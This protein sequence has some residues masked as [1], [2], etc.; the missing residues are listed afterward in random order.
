MKKY[1]FKT[2]TAFVTAMLL[3][4]LVGALILPS[5]IPD[6]ALVSPDETESSWLP[7]GCRWLCRVKEEPS[8]QVWQN[9]ADAIDKPKDESYSAT[10]YLCGV[11]PLKTVELA[12]TDT[13]CVVP[14]GQAIGISLRPDGILVAA[15]A[16]VDTPDG[17]KSPAKEAGLNAGDIIH[18]ING[19]KMGRVSDVTDFVQKSHETLTIQGKRNQK[20]MEWTVKPAYDK[21]GKAKIGLWIRDTVSGIGTLSFFTDSLFGALGHPISDI[22][23]GKVVDAA[24][25][26]I[27][28]A[29]IVNV[30]KGQ[31]GVPGSLCGIFTSQKIG[32][33]TQNTDCGVFGTSAGL[34]GKKV[35]IGRKEDIKCTKAELWCDIGNG[36]EHFDIEIVRVM[37]SADSSKGMVIHI[38]DDALI[39]RTGGIVQGMSGSPILQNGKLIGAVTHVFVNDPTRGYGIFIENMLAEAEKI[40]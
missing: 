30:D 24:G 19:T 21:N 18:T 35:P 12:R 29:S 27:Y 33:I 22:D 28:S 26:N 38:T 15:V 20:A 13:L 40:K 11:I 39:E 32:E 2:T 7:D 37:P 10:V 34:S 4:A 5:A 17:Q 14:G 16:D 6:K 9:S 23:T 36:V 8:D 1:K 3:F 31:K 25:G